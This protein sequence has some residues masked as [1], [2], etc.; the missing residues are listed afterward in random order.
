MCGEVNETL[1]GYSNAGEILSGLA[2]ELL[3]ATLNQRV[4]KATTY[5]RHSHSPAFGGATSETTEEVRWR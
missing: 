5:G 2:E 1:P 3:D 4:A